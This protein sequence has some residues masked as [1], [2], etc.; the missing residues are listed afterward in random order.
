MSKEEILQEFSD[1][2]EM[3]NNCTKYDTLERMIDE[4]IE[5]TVL[6]QEPRELLLIKLDAYIQK[7]TLKKLVNDIEI[8]KE[9]GIIILPP[10]CEPLLVPKDIEIITENPN[11]SES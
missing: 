3:Y 7:E 4:L 5:Q 8:G 9:K 1:I 10:Y 11:E 2:N 6:S